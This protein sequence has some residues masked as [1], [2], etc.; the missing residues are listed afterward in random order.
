MTKIEAFVESMKPRNMKERKKLIKTISQVGVR[1]EGDHYAIMV[2]KEL[3]GIPYEGDLYILPMLMHATPLK[4]YEKSYRRYAAFT[5]DEKGR[6]WLRITHDDSA[7]DD[8]QQVFFPVRNEYEAADIYA[9]VGTDTMTY[10]WCDHDKMIVPHFRA[11]EGTYLTLAMRTLP[12]SREEMF[13]QVIEN[14][15]LI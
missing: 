3:M 11:N 9:R 10:F 4:V 5:Q 2:P 12:V 6:F 1:N 13:A 15:V 8:Y 7:Y 14:N